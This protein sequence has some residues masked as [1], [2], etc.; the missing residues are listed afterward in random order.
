MSDTITICN[1]QEADTLMEKNEYDVLLSFF[2]KPQHACQS[3]ATH[4]FKGNVRDAHPMDHLND[5]KQVM[6]VIP[7]VIKELIF[8]AREL[9]KDLKV[10]SH[11]RAGRCRSTA[12]AIIFLVARGMSEEDAIEQVY[13]IRGRLCAPN[14]YFLVIADR[15]MGTNILGTCQGQG[16]KLKSF[17]KDRRL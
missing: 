12:G 6:K 3:Q 7:R 1:F 5:S 2:W 8:F 15:Y 10:I 16:R 14:W 17:R 4:T 9:P 13:T 11:C